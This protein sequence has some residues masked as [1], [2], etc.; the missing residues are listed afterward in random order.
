MWAQFANDH[1]WEIA[2]Y[3]NGK[4]L[5]EGN[6]LVYGGKTY[7]LH[8]LHFHS[9]SEH[10]IAGALTDA[11]VHM[12]H[13]TS[14][15]SSALVLAVRLQVSSS[16]NA[17]LRNFWDA[18]NLAD[19]SSMY[20]GVWEKKKICTSAFPGKKDAEMCGQGTSLS[21]KYRY[22][23]YYEISDWDTPLEPYT[24][25]LPANKAFYTYSGS[26]TTYP[27]S[28]GITFVVFE[29]P[30]MIGHKD[31]SIIR[32]A[33]ANEPNTITM[34]EGGYRN[35]R[36]VQDLIDSRPVYKYDPN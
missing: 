13:K 18:A 6:K 11:E 32:S 3:E 35:N 19:S 29:E 10:S 27:C 8:Q 26:L 25:L 23:K 1:A 24:A 12:V 31:L 5:C 34:K 9:P 15:E 14:D 16:P 4:W 33:V 20:Y 36:P 28:E 30:V 2:F 22:S 17:F 21:G 7:Y